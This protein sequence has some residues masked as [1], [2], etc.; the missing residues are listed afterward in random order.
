VILRSERRAIMPAP[1]TALAPVPC[2][3][4]RSCRRPQGVVSPRSATFPGRHALEELGR[5]L[6]R[7]GACCG[8]V[9]RGARGGHALGLERRAE[10]SVVADAF[11]AA[12][13][14]S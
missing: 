2:R 5:I 8:H 4:C 12:A 1:G 6:A 9:Q 11:E 7:W 13:V 10:Q 3:R 14:A